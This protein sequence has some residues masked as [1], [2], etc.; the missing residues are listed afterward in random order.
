MS[1]RRRRTPAQINGKLR[2]AEGLLNAGQPMSVVVQ[3][4]GISMATYYRWRRL[5]WPVWRWRYAW[6]WIVWPFWLMSD[7]GRSTKRIILTF[8][9][10]AVAFPA[11]TPILRGRMIALNRL[12]ALQAGPTSPDVH[13]SRLQQ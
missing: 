6:H 4:M 1:G 11:A 7:Y 9:I 3:R 12:L 13:P 5:V 8:L 10:L 2:E